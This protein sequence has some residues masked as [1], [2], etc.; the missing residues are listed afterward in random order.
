MVMNCKRAR[1]HIALHVG[2]DLDA[3]GVVELDRHLAACA[4][5][6]DYTA[7]FAGPL[8][9][10]HGNIVKPGELQDSLWPELLD[11]LPARP[12]NRIL[13][14]NGWW[15]ALAVSAACLAILMFWQD[16]RRRRF[17]SDSGSIVGASSNSFPTARPA[18]GAPSGERSVGRVPSS[19]PNFPS[20][21]VGLLPQPNPQGGPQPRI[22]P[23]NPQLP[24][25][26]EAF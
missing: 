14:F 15:I 11:K 22:C 3:A 7:Q 10:L 8:D 18:G 17:T 20:V 16:E 1:L 13:E 12:G 5:C 23:E 4:D 24:S 6:R 25:F 19:Q 2:D 21:A 9:S 26:F